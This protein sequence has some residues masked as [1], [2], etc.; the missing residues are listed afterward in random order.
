VILNVMGEL[1]Q[2]LKII[3]EV[4]KKGVMKKS[5]KEK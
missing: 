2:A 5:Q 3:F 1:P 4:Q